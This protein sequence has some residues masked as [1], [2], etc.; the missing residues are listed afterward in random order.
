MKKIFTIGISALMILS[1]SSAAIAA[2]PQSFCQVEQ[3]DQIS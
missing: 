3:C 1:V 2:E